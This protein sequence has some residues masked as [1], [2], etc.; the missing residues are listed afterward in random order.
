[1]GWM[2]RTH[3]PRTDLGQNGPP[4]GIQ[5][6]QSS[7]WLKH[8]VGYQNLRLVGGIQESRARMRGAYASFRQHDTERC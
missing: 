1:M 8:H 4:T 6:T 2:C 5:E 7:M 3:D